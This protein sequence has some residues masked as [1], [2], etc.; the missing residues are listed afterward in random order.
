VGRLAAELRAAGDIEAVR[1]LATR[2]AD[3]I[4]A[5]DPEFLAEWLEEFRG[6]GAAEAVPILLARDPA[7]QVRLDHPGHVAWLLEELHAADAGAVAGAG[8]AVRTLLARDPGGQARLD[9]PQD[10]ARLLRALR[11]V[12]AGDAV[13]C[14][15]AR[16]AEGASLENPQDTA[17]LLEELQR[18]GAGDAVRALLARDP[19]AR[20]SPGPGQQ[21]GVARLLQALR[22][23]GASEAARALAARAANAGM[24]GLEADRASYRFGREPDGTPAPPW[25]WMIPPLAP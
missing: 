2:V 5:G 17:W 3:S 11:V 1:T 16:A 8:D 14:L 4:P 19:A 23:A 20:V 9:H 7:S 6:A 15:A 12:G 22:T 10:V 21:R 25:R 18:C 24:F 13:T